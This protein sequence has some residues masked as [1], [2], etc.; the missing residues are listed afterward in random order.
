MMRSDLGEYPTYLYDENPFTDVKY[1]FNR[2]VVFDYV[3]SMTKNNDAEEFVPGITSFD[4]YSNWMAGYTFG[5]SSVCPNGIDSLGRGEAIHLTEEE[6]E[7]ILGNIRQNVI[8]LAKEYPDVTFYLFFPPYS[9]V[10]WQ[11]LT[12][13]GTIYREIEARTLAVEEILQYSN[14]KIY[15][16]NNRIDLTADLNNYKDDSHY[17]S[18]INSL[19]LRW[20]RDD[21]YLLTWNNYQEYLQEEF[22]LYTSYD[23]TQ[24]TGQIDYENDYYAEA[25]MCKELKGIEP[26][27]FTEEQLRGCE[28]NSASIVP[29]QYDGAVGIECRG[30]IQREFE[31]PISDYLI[32]S[33][34]IGCKIVV[35]DIKD[36]SYL[37]FYGKKSAD[38]G[39]PYILLHDLNGNELASLSRHYSSID[40]EWHHYLLDVSDLVGEVT[41]IFNGGYI[42]HTGS[43]ESTFTFS[44][45]TLY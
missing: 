29:N 9:A 31:I 21:S 25:L 1:L 16:F 2:Q 26:L 6:R 13:D 28:L 19:I 37:S 24:M 7:I 45:I 18:W 34:Y 20:M 3:Y 42:D 43:P 41:I 30:S 23:Y 27:E 12:A 5:T 38:H 15:S 17:G 33:E 22:S 11:S 10:W 44:G 35:E 14:I 8:S 4:Q 32:H 40:S 39:Q 36:Y